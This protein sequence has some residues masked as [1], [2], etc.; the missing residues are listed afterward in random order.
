MEQRGKSE[1]EEEQHRDEE[2]ASERHS[3][4]GDVPVFGAAKP[5]A[6]LALWGGCLCFWSRYLAL[7]SSQD[8]QKLLH[9][10]IKMT[11]LPKDVSELLFVP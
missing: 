4:E 8:F 10:C 9:F 5:K 3:W 7:C 2:G 11:R 1:Q 6:S